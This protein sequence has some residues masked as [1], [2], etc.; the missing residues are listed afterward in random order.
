MDF[1]ITGKKIKGTANPLQNATVLKPTPKKTVPVKPV[2][3]LTKPKSSITS[4]K[5][6]QAKVSKPETKPSPKKEEE[7]AKVEVEEKKVDEKVEEKP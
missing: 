6:Q 1:A 4:A 2:Q 3:P 5:V 7:P